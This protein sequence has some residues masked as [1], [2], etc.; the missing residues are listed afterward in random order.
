LFSFFTLVFSVRLR[1]CDCNPPNVLRGFRFT[2][3]NK[4]NALNNVREY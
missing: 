2:A 1:D 3:T 4:M